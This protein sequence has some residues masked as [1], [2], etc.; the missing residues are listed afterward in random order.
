VTVID[1]SVLTSFILM[2]PGWER[3][4]D[5]LKNSYTIDHAVKEASN[6]IWK[7]HRK[8]IIS[9]EDASLKFQALRKLVSVNV[10]L[11][12]EEELIDQAFT[13]S[14]KYNITVYDAL[15]IALALKLEEPLLT[16]DHLQAE[17]AEKLGVELVKI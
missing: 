2:E 16:L 4:V 6:A 15:Y 10:K 17:I 5:L 13:L 11:V 8:G 9:A 3:L 1:A 12:K 14:L 7:A